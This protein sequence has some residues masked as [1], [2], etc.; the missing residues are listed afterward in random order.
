MK[1]ILEYAP[2]NDEFFYTTSVPIVF[3]GT[4]EELKKSIEDQFNLLKNS[5]KFTHLNFIIGKN[6]K[7]ISVSDIIDDSFNYLRYDLF[8]VDEWFAK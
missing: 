3:D 6:K 4:K 2:P 5:N 8:T 7:K 1:Y